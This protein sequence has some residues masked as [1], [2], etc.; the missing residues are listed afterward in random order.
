MVLTLLQVLSTWCLKKT[1]GVFNANVGYSGY[2][3]PAFN[4]GKSVVASQYPHGGAIDGNGITIDANYGLA[5]GKNGGF[6]NFTGD[7]AKNGKTF[8]QT[9]DTTTSNPAA[10]PI[11]PYRR[12][13]G[14]GSAESGTFFFNHESCLAGKTTLYSFGGYSY[15]ASDAYAF[16]R[17][18]RAD[19]SVSLPTTAL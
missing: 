14:D 12:A 15:K 5:L 7:Y 17:N 11:N 3:D 16:T 8:R 18:F 1:T 6:I 13:N 9:H 19:Q 2:Y 4:S 10:L